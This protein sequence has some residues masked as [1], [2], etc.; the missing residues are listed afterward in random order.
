MD[1]VIFL[2]TVRRICS[3]VEDCSQCPISWL[4]CGCTSKEGQENTMV[5]RVE[6]WIKEHPVKTILSDS[7]EKFP[8][9]P[10]DRSGIPYG[11]CVEKLGY[12]GMD[13]NG[14]GFCD[15]CWN[16]PIE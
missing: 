12:K 15:E 13:C 9:A 2:K 11:I 1:A 16:Q 7:L 3:M 5:A 14:D 6:E 10:L 4:S 8:N